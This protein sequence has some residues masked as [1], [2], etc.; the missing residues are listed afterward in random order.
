MRRLENLLENGAG[1]KIQTEAAEVKRGK[2]QSAEER[3]LERAGGGEVWLGSAQG[4]RVRGRRPP[5]RIPS[6][7]DRTGLALGAGADEDTR[8]GAQN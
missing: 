3:H 7:S 2:S 8:A 5:Q 6:W 4:W 1:L